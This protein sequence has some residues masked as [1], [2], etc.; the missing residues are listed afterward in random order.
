[1]WVV[2][3]ILE[4]LCSK[5][6][7]NDIVGQ[8]LVKTLQRLSSPAGIHSVQRFQCILISLQEAILETENEFLMLRRISNQNQVIK[9]DMIG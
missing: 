8:I 2:I 6:A 5:A 7:L 9:L 1:M 3:I 4:K